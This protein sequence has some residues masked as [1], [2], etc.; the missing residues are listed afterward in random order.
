MA[1]NFVAKAADNRDEKPRER[2]W[3]TPRGRSHKRQQGQP[4]VHAERANAARFGSVAASTCRP[5]ARP[6]GDTPTSHE[7]H[8]RPEHDSPGREQ[9]RCDRRGLRRERSRVASGLFPRLRIW[10]KRNIRTGMRPVSPRSFKSGGCSGLN[11]SPVR[12][13]DT[14]ATNGPSSNVCGP[15]WQNRSARRR[16]AARHGRGDENVPHQ[17]AARNTCSISAC[18]G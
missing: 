6:P 16:N 3:S 11:E 1:E 17:Y 8:E 13:Y 5:A 9:C 4:E 2:S 12:Q 7:T 14:P 18:V 10:L 15:R